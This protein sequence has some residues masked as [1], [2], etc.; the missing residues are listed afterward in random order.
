MPR[1]VLGSPSDWQFALMTAM[2]ADL[3]YRGITSAMAK[4]RNRYRVMGS[5]VE[6]RR[7]LR[8][9]YV[10]LTTKTAESAELSS[11]SDYWDL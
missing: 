10:E 6:F 3:T 7:D 9:P 1:C 11:L 4:L 2:V 8:I 5:A